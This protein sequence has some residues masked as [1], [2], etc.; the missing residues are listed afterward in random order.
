[1]DATTSHRL[2]SVAVPLAAV[3]VVTATLAA[4]DANLT[5]AALCFV[6]VVVG[7]ALLGAFAGTVS[8]FAAFL[9]T[10]YFFTAPRRSFAI[11]KTEDVVALFVFAV[12]AAVVTATVSRV[13]ALRRQAVTQGREART[14]LE[15]NRRI[16]A[17]E[18]PARVL[19][20][21]GD[22]VRELFGFTDCRVT[23]AADGRLTVVT[24]PG[25]ELLAPDEKLLLDAF[26]ND[27][28]ASL[29]RVRLEREAQIARGAA[30]VEEARASFLSAMTHNLRTPLASIGAAASVLLDPAARLERP[31]EVQLLE[32]VRSE[33][34]RLDRLVTK[35][36]SLGR[37][38]S[39]ALLLAPEAVDVDELIRSAARR[40]QIVGFG[41]IQLVA[42]D[43]LPAVMVDPALV[44]IALVNVLEN[45][46][47]YS[48]GEIGVHVELRGGLVAVSVTDRG[49]GVPLADRERVFERF[50]R[51]SENRDATGAGI[52]LAITREFVHA[53]HGQCWIEETPG[54]GATV[55]MT[56]P[57]APASL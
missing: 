42:P 36:L 18:D 8:V 17:G 4:A 31:A 37:I 33:A 6:P 1:V 40:M 54:G 53:H 52:G 45:A 47:R 5:V 30:E 34:D 28:G 12:S 23:L 21:V 48:G 57:I 24:V 25:A 49:P 2:K 55:V 3:A 16:G 35:V 10:N 22:S 51:G 56:L 14:R 32:T 39:G 7:S 15:L 26:V 20:S 43:D 50:V 27:V 9:A 29:D 41:R 19:A 11:D 46:L 38:Q 13:N 44:E